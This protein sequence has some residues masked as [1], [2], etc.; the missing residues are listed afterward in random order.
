MEI[1]STITRIC[2]FIAIT[3]SHMACKKDG[4][5]VTIADRPVIQSY[6]TNGSVVTFK[7]YQQK[8]LLDTANYGAPISGLTVSFNNGNKTIT[9]EE[10]ST[11]TYSSTETDR[12]IPGNKCSF[13]FTYNSETV[14]GETLV[15]SK[16]VGFTSSSAEQAVPDPSPDSSTTSFTAVNFTWNNTEKGYYLLV[17][18]NQESTPTRI[19]SGFGRRN[20]YQ[21]REEYLAQASSFKTQRMTFEFAGYYDVYLYHI[22]EEYNNIINSS[23][24]SSLNLT[25]P[26]TN[27]KNGLGIFTAMGTASVLLHVYKE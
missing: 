15:P 7:V 12:I 19:G 1:R 3:F 21:D 2:F 14:S 27:I 10:T 25:N 24:T 22:N 26:P 18:K 5:D 17:F 16:P 13:S 9:L 4:G 20:A 6:L 8:G 23:S 11:G